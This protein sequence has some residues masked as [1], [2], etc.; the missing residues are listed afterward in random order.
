MESDGCC[1]FFC[2]CIGLGWKLK[3]KWKISRKQRSKH[4]SAVKTARRSVPIGLWA[5]RSDR[6]VGALRRYWSFARERATYEYTALPPPGN[7]RT[8]SLL[9]PSFAPRAFPLLLITASLSVHRFFAS[10][11]TSG[12]LPF[13]S[14]IS[15]AGKTKRNLIYF[16]TPFVAARSLRKK[17][18]FSSFIGINAQWIWKCGV[19]AGLSGLCCYFFFWHLDLRY[20]R[21]EDYWKKRVGRRLLFCSYLFES[22]FRTGETTSSRVMDSGLN[23]SIKLVGV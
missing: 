11:Y 19:R 1:F 16:F 12:F 13:D 22:W 10:L 8:P 5:R 9:P 17:M 21:K 4:R 18:S 15:S 6:V 20:G 3:K 14:S 2:C 7:I 23:S